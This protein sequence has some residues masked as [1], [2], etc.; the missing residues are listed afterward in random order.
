MAGASLT[1]SVIASEFG[2]IGGLFMTCVIF[3]FAFTS[4]IGN[5]AYSEMAMV[6][7]G[8]GNTTGLFGQAAVI[9]L[10]GQVG[11]TVDEASQT[12]ADSVFAST[13]GVAG[14]AAFN[15]NLAQRMGYTAAHEGF[16]TFS[17]VHTP[18]ENPPTAGANARLSR[19]ART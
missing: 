1:Q 10:G 3:L 6:Y 2:A 18:D 8:V 12:Y 4:I 14:T 9:D 7:I 16:H 11:N 5:Y 17:Y 13:S 19:R 15:A